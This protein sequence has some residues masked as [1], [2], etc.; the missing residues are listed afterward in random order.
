[1]QQSNSDNVRSGIWI[2]VNRKIADFGNP[3]HA[4]LQE[5]RYITRGIYWG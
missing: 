5:T 4:A 3:D 2:D 1:M